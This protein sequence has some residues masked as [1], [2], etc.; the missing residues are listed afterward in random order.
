MNSSVGKQIKGLFEGT[1][2]TCTRC[3]KCNATT[4]RREM[5]NVLTLSIPE[6]GTTIE[7]AMEQYTAEVAMAGNN[8]YHC[9]INCQG[10]C[11]AVQGTLLQL[12]CLLVLA[13]KRFGSE[14]AGP[15]NSTQATFGPT[16]QCKNSS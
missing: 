12:P 15:K 16:L 2:M 3:L 11:D 13:L 5:F 8:Q 7:Q 14:G 1:S 6:G 10:L 4:E 9:E